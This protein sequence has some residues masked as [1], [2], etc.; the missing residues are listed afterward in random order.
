VNSV[1]TLAEKTS[2][3]VDIAPVVIVLVHNGSTSKNIDNLKLAF[4]NILHVIS[5]ENLGY[6]GGANLCL[7]KGFELGEWTIFLSNDC[8]LLSWPS[9]NLEI[10]KPTIVA[11]MVRRRNGRQVDSFGGVFYPSRAELRHFRSREDQICLKRKPRYLKYVPGSTFLIHKLVFEK[12]HGFD[13]KLGTY[14]ED[15]DLS[16]R[17]QAAQFEL[18]FDELWNVEHKVGKTCHGNSLYTLY[19]YQRNRKRMTLKYTNWN[20]L[21]KASFY[22]TRDWIRLCFRLVKSGRHSDLKLLRKAIFEI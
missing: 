22:L 19:Y 3:A 2:S 16:I 17:A 13:T 8:L 11:P 21:P 18:T 6:S 4:P 20:E 15:V 5:T 7:S 1:L 10:E 12:T 14:W 9:L